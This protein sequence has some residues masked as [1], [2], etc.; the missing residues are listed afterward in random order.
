MEIKQK[1]AK[2]IIDAYWERN[3]AIKAFAKS[4]ATKDAVGKTWVRNPINRFWYELRSEKDIFSAVNQS[5]GAYIFD[6]WVGFTLKKVKRITLQM[7]D[8]QAIIVKKGYRPQIEKI[9][10]ESIEKV[11]KLL[12]LNRDMDIDIQ[13]GESYAD[14]H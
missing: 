8:E 10:K 6:L 14:V 4:C 2:A 9:F 7:H 13:W 1:E 3:W 5:T 11:N 12:S